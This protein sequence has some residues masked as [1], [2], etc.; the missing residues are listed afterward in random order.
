LG[1]DPAEIFAQAAG[2]AADDIGRR[3]RAF[4]QR[5]DVT[6]Q[7]YGWREFNTPRGVRYRFDW[8]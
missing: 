1:L 7:K 4:G 6:L 2:Y 3:M 5:T 8:R